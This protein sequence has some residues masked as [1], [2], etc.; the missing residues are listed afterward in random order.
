MTHLIGA[1][2]QVV[3]PKELRDALGLRP[4]QAVQFDRDGEHV[5]V[6]KVATAESLQGRFAGQSLTDDLLR[7]RRD[8]RTKEDRRR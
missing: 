8:E 1:K 5:V 2:G 6:R 7:S 3:I 4:G